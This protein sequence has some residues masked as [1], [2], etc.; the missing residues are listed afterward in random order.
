MNNIVQFPTEFIVTEIGLSS[1]CTLFLSAKHLP[2][3]AYLIPNCIFL[4]TPVYSEERM[5][6]TNMFCLYMT[7]RM[8][9]S[10]LSQFGVTASEIMCRCILLRKFLPYFTLLERN[11]RVNK[12]HVFSIGFFFLITEQVLVY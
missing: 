3:P 1:I 6:K 9:F 8:C 11:V 2:P 4:R 7:F 10:S 12:V 5:I